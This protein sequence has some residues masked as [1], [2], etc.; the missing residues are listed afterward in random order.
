M[1]GAAAEIDLVRTKFDFFSYGP[2]PQADFRLVYRTGLRTLNCRGKPE[3]PI[4]LHITTQ[5]DHTSVP[6]ICGSV[7]K[8]VITGR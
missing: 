7:Y 5:H 8:E 3:Q 4:E 6:K 1:N 2:I